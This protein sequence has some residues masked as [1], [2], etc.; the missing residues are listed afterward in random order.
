MNIL[1]LLR[2]VHAILASDREALYEAE[3]MPGTGQV[4]DPEARQIIGEYDDILI[5]LNTV[6]AKMEAI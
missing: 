4:P 5:E 3:R 1:D 6:I 2:R